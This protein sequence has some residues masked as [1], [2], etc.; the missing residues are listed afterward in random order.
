M[1]TKSHDKPTISPNKKSNMAI[2]V[3]LIE[4]LCVSKYAGTDKAKGVETKHK[5]DWIRKTEKKCFN[6]SFTLKFGMEISFSFIGISISKLIPPSLS[7][8]K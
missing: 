5:M 8:L 2:N 7:I 6:L 3:A 4:K 1:D